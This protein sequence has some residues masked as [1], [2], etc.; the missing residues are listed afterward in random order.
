MS[1]EILLMG[2]YF[3]ALS[4]PL[5]IAIFFQSLNS[6]PEGALVLSTCKL[7]PQRQVLALQCR[8]NPTS[9]A[10]RR[11]PQPPSIFVGSPGCI[12]I[13]LAAF[14]L[15]PPFPPLLPQRLLTIL[16]QIQSCNLATHSAPYNTPVPASGQPESYSVLQPC[17]VLG[18][19]YTRP[20]VRSA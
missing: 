12:Q 17:N 2:G 10:G 20:R 18:Q 5:G 11:R 9:A 7:V 6:G 4:V 19:Y 16:N 3:V 14:L 8:E 1:R 15:S 13:P